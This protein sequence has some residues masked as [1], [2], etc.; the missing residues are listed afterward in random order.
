MIPWLVLLPD[1]HDPTRNAALTL[2][3]QGT[4]GGEAAADSNPRPFPIMAPL[5]AKEKWDQLYKSHLDWSVP[6]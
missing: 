1:D 2:G 3:Q 5:P 6:N 4:S